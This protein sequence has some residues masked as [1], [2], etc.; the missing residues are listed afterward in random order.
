MALQPPELKYLQGE[1]R[2]DYDWTTGEA[3]GAFL[4]ALRDH[5]KILAGVCG[6]CGQVSV[7]PMSYCEACGEEMSELREVGPRGVVMSWA[8]VADDFEGAPVAAPFR[9]VLVRLAGADTELLHIAPDDDGVRIGAAVRPEFW[10]REQ[11]SG[12]ITDIRWFVPDGAES[13]GS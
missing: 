10:P 1:S 2:C 3:V 7:P 12:A 4:A 11:R 9:Y 6:A 13:E 5:G 8:R